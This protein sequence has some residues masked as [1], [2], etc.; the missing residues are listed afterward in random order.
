[1]ILGFPDYLAPA[2]RLAKQLGRSFVSVDVHSFPD[3][4]SRVQVPASLPTEII[5]CRS[6]NQP[7]N[8]LIELILACEAARQH[9]ALHITLVAPYLCYMR[10]DIE[11]QPGEAVSARTIGSMLAQYVDRIVTVDPHLHRITTLAEA[12]PARNALALSAAPLLAEFIADQFDDPLLIGP[13]AESVQWVRELAIPRDW[14]FGVAQKHRS[15]DAA[16]EIRLPDIDMTNRHVVMIDDMISTGHTIAQAALAM[17]Q[18]G[19]ASISC[20]VTHGLF[21]GDALA[22]LYAAGLTKVWSTDSVPHETNAVDL[23]PLIANALR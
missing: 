12:V 15:G 16:V 23:A 7:N 13:D 21:V 2:Q 4:E 17:Q 11:F 19:A 3:G 10:Q 18:R 22:K 8:K 20:I 5:F 6:L 1:M 14:Q 9:G